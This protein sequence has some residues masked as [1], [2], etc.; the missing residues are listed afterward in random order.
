MPPCACYMFRKFIFRHWKL[1]SSQDWNIYFHCFCTIPMF[2]YFLGILGKN[3]W[4][5]VRPKLTNT[6]LL[7]KQAST[8]ENMKRK[9]EKL[10]ASHSNFNIWFGNLQIPRLTVE[11]FPAWNK[12]WQWTDITTMQPKNK[13]AIYTRSQSHKNNLQSQWQR[14]FA[15]TQIPTTTSINQKRIVHHGGGEKHGHAVQISKTN[16]RSTKIQK[17]L[18][19]TRSEFSIT[20]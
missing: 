18:E 16:W 11:N 5:C 2:Q 20:K 14:K 13:S 6:K 3:T 4:T 7:F 9:W 8:K 17:L 10:L 19:Q 12:N 1:I 15:K